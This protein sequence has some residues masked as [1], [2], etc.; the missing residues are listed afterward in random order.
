MKVV[1]LAG[2]LPSTIGEAEEPEAKPMVRIGERPLLWHIM[3]QFSHFGFHDF[4]I[5]SGYRSESIKEYFMNYYMYR[6]DITVHLAS[7]AVDIHHKI[8]EPWRVSIVD[9]GLT[10]STADRIFRVQK[11]LAD[12][13]FFI[14]FGDCLSNIDA[15]AMMKTHL[16][17]GKIMT[18]A[19][20]RPTGRNTIIPTAP[21]GSLLH[22]GDPGYKIHDAWVN[23]DTMIC[24]PE[25]FQNVS[26]WGGRFEIEVVK[27]LNEIGQVASFRHDGFWLPVETVRDRK[28]AQALWDSGNVPWRVWEDG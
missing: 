5:C 4:L 14:V 25:I 26:D 6:S 20:A 12:E 9:T 27:A 24:S 16:D 7:N 18:L 17:A 2:G 15:R 10:A 3:K 23:A 21:D 11:F 8:T 22:P 19:L 28:A 13:P 1:I